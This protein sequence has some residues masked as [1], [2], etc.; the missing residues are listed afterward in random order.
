MAESLE[1]SEACALLQGATAAALREDQESVRLAVGLIPA[2]MLRGSLVVVL[3]AWAHGLMAPHQDR[4][5]E[6]VAAI[7]EVLAAGFLDSLRDSA[8]GAGD[9]G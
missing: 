9:D 8:D 1:W 7:R 2:T 4:G 3:E 6:N 5:S